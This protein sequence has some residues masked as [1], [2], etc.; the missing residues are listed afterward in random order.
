[1]DSVLRILCIILPL[2]ITVAFFTLAERKLLSGIQRRRGP[3]TVGFFGLT[4]AL[5]DGLKLFSKEGV[6][7]ARAN[8]L[9]FTLAPLIRFSISL[10]L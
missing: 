4:Q 2:L 8:L 10:I 6:Q 9:I 7:P 5:A 1:M 3:N